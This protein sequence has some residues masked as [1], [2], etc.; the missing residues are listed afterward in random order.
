M[1]LLLLYK[2]LGVSGAKLTLG[3]R[4]FK[5]AKPSDFNDTED[6]TIQSIFA[7]DIEE[8][9]KKITGSFP[10]VIMQYLYEEPTCN[11]PT[12]ERIKIIQQVYRA[13]P[14]AAELFR[15]DRMMEKSDID[16]IIGKARTVN[17]DIKI[18]QAKRGGGGKLV[19]GNGTWRASM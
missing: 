15:T 9:L 14:G 16:D 4:T 2:Y 13:N 1:T 10:D 12:K 7:E 3:N 19:F 11:S 18:F 6:L 5:H 8:A 17:R